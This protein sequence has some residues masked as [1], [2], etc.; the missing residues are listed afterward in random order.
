MDARDAIAKFPER[1]T[2]IAPRLDN[3]GE[4]ELFLPYDEEDLLNFVVAPSPFYQHQANRM[5][6]YWNRLGKKKWQKK[7]SRL[8][9]INS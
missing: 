7:W 6:D 9:I 2:A 5:V 4:S 8:R 3:Q 1:C